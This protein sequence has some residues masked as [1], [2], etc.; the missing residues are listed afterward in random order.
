MMMRNVGGIAS[1]VMVVGALVLLSSR[2]SFE[3]QVPALRPVEVTI[4]VAAPVASFSLAQIASDQHLWPAG[5]HVTWT[6]MSPTTIVSSLATGRVQLVLGAPPQYDVG[7]YNG[8][9]PIEWIAQW[10]DPADFQMIVRPGIASVADLKGKVIAATAIGSSTALLA[11]IALQKAGLQ[12]SDYKILPMGDVGSAIAAFAAGSASSLVSSA[13]T[14][15]PLISRI[16]GAKVAY[17]FYYEKVPWIGAG[18][19]AYQP[20]VVKNESATIAVLAALNKA[21]SLVHSDPDLVEPSV[22][23]FVGAQSPAAA[24][25]QQ[26]YLENRTPASLG[27][28]SLRTLQSIY[29]AVRS[30]SNGLGPSD[31][32]AR[33]AVD[34]RYVE[35]MLAASR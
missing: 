15:Q 27:P 7:A 18:V 5:V 30:A 34:N 3:A 16:P 14:V 31:A 22:S 32:F 12:S 2:S 35:K 33:S 20:W 1:L 13:S 26:R 4:G 10:Q 17:D 9:V 11:E 21:L 24:A 6:T 19:V 8:K 29:A 23:K 25:V 28:V